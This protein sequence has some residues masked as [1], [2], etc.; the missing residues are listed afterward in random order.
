MVSTGQLQLPP[1]LTLRPIV[2]NY[3]NN[4]NRFTPSFDQASFM[5]MI[6]DWHSSTARQALVRW[7]AGT[8]SK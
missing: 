8:S 6:L 1:L 7:A 4:Y 3:F 5:R 2:N